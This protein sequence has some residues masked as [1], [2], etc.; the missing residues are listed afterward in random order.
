MKFLSR[1]RDGAALVQNKILYGVDGDDCLLTYCQLYIKKTNVISI[2]GI[3]IL[4]FFL[5]SIFVIKENFTRLTS[6]FNIPYEQTYTKVTEISA[7][8]RIPECR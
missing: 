7:I 6:L 4:Q 3:I 8:A 1:F 2:N 5:V